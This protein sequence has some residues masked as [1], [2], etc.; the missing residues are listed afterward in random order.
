MFV[1]AEGP[2]FAYNYKSAVVTC[3]VSAIIPSHCRFAKLLKSAY[4]LANIGADTAEI[5]V[6]K[7]HQAAAPEAAGRFGELLCSRCDTAESW[8]AG[9]QWLHL[10]PLSTY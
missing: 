10:C 7:W 1:V 5:L 9:P 4:L 2:Q 8:P 3:S 6:T